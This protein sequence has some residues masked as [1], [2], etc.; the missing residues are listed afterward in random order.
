MPDLDGIHRIQTKHPFLKLMRVPADSYPGQTADL[1]SVG[2]WSFIMAR[3]SLPDEVAYRLARALPRGEAALAG[4]LAQG[5]AT[6]AAKTITAVARPELLHPA[7]GVPRGDRPH[8]LTAWGQVLKYD[9]S[10]ARR[11]A[12]PRNVVFQA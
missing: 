5:R 11:S 9:I 1:V 6:T 4:R 8:A 3:P 10:A 12:G 7:C 2:S